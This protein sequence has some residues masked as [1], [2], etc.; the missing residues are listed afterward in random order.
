MVQREFEE[1]KKMDG[2]MG[3]ISDGAAALGARPQDAAGEQDEAS[4]DFQW[5][6]L[7]WWQEQ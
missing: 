4:P 7:W 1:A 6:G 2:T 3:G 5:N